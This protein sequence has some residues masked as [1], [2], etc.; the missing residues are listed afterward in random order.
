M[1]V[2]APEYTGKYDQKTIFLPLFPLFPKEK[3][4][5]D[6]VCVLIT[7]TSWG[8]DV[9]PEVPGPKMEVMSRSVIVKTRELGGGIEYA[10]SDIW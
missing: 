4:I 9:G 8:E 7:G 3:A 1:R 10:N 5:L 6:H 2:V